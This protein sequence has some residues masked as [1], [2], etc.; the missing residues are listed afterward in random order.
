MY[1][2]TQ[3]TAFKNKDRISLSVLPVTLDT[4]LK[5]IWPS[6]RAVMG[7]LANT[8]AVVCRYKSENFPPAKL[9]GRISFAYTKLWDMCEMEY[10]CNYEVHHSHTLIFRAQKRIKCCR[11]N[12][13]KLYLGH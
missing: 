7:H 12:A 3:I 11:V 8:S 10:F 6:G 2:Y 4:A 9:S 13:V 5:I 1:C